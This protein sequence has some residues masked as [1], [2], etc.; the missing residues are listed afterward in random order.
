MEDSFIAEDDN[1]VAYELAW[2]KTRQRVIR[3]RLGDNGYC[4]VVRSSGPGLRVGHVIAVHICRHN[5]C[6]ARWNIM[7]YG[8]REPKTHFQRLET[9]PSGG[10][11]SVVVADNA[12]ASEPSAAVA[13]DYALPM[14]HAI[15]A[16]DHVDEQEGSDVN[17]V[18]Q[19]DRHSDDKLA[20]VAE[21]VGE[22]EVDE[23]VTRDGLAHLGSFDECE[24][25]KTLPRVRL[26]RCHLTKGH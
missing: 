11:S 25:I 19:V 3:N 22:G 14:G 24:S 15:E 10:D 23:G 17:A 26:R 21:L 8:C 16:D 1:G 7:K 2:D 4:R 9:W 13:A 6:Q 20:E 12:L 18:G 5:P